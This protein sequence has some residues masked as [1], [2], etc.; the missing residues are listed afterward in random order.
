[1]ITTEKF[2]SPA[3]VIRQH[4]K[5]S[6]LV[7]DETDLGEWPSY[8]GS[9][10]DTEDTPDDA[11]CIY[12]TAGMKDGRSMRS[13]Q[14][15]IHEGWMIH[16]RSSDYDVGRDKAK[17][18]FE[19]LSREVS[20][21]LVTIEAAVYQIVSVSMTSGIFSLGESETR[22]RRSFSLNG[23]VSINNYLEA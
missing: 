18:L 3:R 8:V 7:T 4:L 17:E 9:M 1:M 12:D 16:V 6:S 11:I 23:I 22:N 21:V 10:P 19:H 15:W 2:H 20:D 13:G 5:E 14:V